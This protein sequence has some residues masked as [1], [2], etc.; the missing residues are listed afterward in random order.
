MGG[1]ALLQLFGMIPATKVD[2]KDD[3]KEDLV[4]LPNESAKHCV[5]KFAP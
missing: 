2:Y 4:V 1:D 5:Q 3:L